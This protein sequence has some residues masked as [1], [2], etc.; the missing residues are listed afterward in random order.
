MM[1]RV[2]CQ[3][4]RTLVGSRGM[5][6]FRALTAS[7]GALKPAFDTFSARGGLWLVRL[8]TVFDRMVNLVIEKVTLYHVL[9]FECSLVS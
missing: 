2:A 8:L 5:G 6:V 4:A 3:A 1:I 7:S 9:S